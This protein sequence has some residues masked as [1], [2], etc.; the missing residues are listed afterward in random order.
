M[1]ETT[2]TTIQ[3]VDCGQPAIVALRPIRRGSVISSG[4]FQ[5][6]DGRPM[7]RGEMVRCDSCHRGFT[8]KFRPSGV[9]AVS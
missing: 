8:F 1:A 4:D 2:L 3:H 7:R 5:H 9:V 6:I